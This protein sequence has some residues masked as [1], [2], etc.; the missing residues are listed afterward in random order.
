LNIYS[1]KTIIKKYRFFLFILYC[2]FFASC[3]QT[4]K[5]DGNNQLKDPIVDSEDFDVFN[6]RF[7]SDS[8]FQYS[9]IIFP[10]EGQFIG[11]FEKHNWTKDNWIIL[12]NPV[13]EK[14]DS[15]EYQHSFSKS[16]SLVIEKFWLPES[17]FKV[18][19]RFKRIDNLWFLVYYSDVNL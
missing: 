8:I 14:S 17:G 6:I 15:N 13:V 12:K 10:L 16:D 2:S 19:R 3:N 18:E 5:E 1:S 4:A 9:R 11:G 7:Y